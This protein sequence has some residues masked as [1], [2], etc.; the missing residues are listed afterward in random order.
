VAHQQNGLIFDSRN[1]QNLTEMLSLAIC[2]TSLRQQMR[3]NAAKTASTGFTMR[4][5]L[6]RHEALYTR[7]L[8]RPV[9][10]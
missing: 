3:Q 8:E 4:M 7:L 10:S 2:E 6:D 5:A 9:Q 1:Q